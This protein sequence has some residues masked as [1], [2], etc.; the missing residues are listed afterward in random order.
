MFGGPGGH[1]NSIY[2]RIAAGWLLLVEAIFPFP[3]KN[4]TALAGVKPS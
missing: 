2:G 1:S 3:P 4:E